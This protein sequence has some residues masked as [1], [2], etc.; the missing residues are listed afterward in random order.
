MARAVLI[1]LTLAA[2]LAA[3]PAIAEGPL[4]VGSKRFTESYILGAIAVKVAEQAGDAAVSHQQGLGGTAV[5]YRALEEGSIDVYPEYTGTIV[6]TILHDKGPMDLAAIRRGLESKGILASDPLGFDN[7]YALAVPAKIARERRL[8]KISDLASAPDLRFG[9]SPEFLG[10]A[11][12]WPGLSARYALA[13]ASVKSLDHGLAYDAVRQGSID[14]MDVYSTDAK[15]KRFDLTVLADDRAFFPSYAAVFLYRKDAVSRAPKAISAL[16]ALAGTIDASA[17][18]DLN[19]LVELDGKTVDSVAV[20][21]VRTHAGAPAI[22]AVRLESR[23]GLFTGV[24]DVIRTEGPRHLALTFGALLL[25]IL[26]GLPLGI[27]AA[28]SRSLG[29]AILASAGVLQT[30]PSLALLCFFIPFLGTGPL[31]A[32]AALFLY[33]LLPIVRNTATGLEGIPP[34]L[35]ESAAALGLPSR[36]RLFLI[37]LP[38]ASRTILAGIKTCAVINVGTATLAAF[39]GAGGFGAPISMGLNLNDTTLILEGA[40]PAAL[41]ALAAEGAFTLLDRVLIPKGLQL[42]EAQAE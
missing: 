39:I 9:L 15:I 8:A 36:A 28:R 33:G 22:G 1:L 14:V 40:I 2:I 42:A 35:L 29:R 16:L 7:T 24:L 41:I 25:S 4:R 5:V 10:R 18:I 17:M 38:L 13:P 32:L 26:A 31:P 12:G 20:E 21:Y 30:I 11:D 34:S 23:M 37:E 3:S 19:A 6:E 27:L